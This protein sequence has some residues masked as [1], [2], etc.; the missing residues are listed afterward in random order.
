MSEHF[1]DEQIAY[2]GSQR[3]GRLATV[4]KDGTVQ[5]NPVG[6]RYNPE[7]GTID[8]G[9]RNMAASRKYRNVAE[10]SKVAFV[11][12]DVPS[13]NP[14]RVRC[15]EIRGEAEAIEDPADST[16]PTAGPIIRIHPRRVLSFGL[17]QS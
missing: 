7:L 2:M 8:I 10:G 6:F 4:R 14:W 11:I 15:L 5:N 13:V 3:L 1:S 16:A 9:G 17:A 12:D